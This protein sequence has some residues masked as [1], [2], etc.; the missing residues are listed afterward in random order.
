MNSL[1]GSELVVDLS[2]GVVTRPLC[3]TSTSGRDSA[4]FQAASDG[5]EFCHDLAAR[6]PIG[7]RH[8][9]AST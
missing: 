9:A 5:R 6:Y 8:I 4:S 2:G 7:P 3:Y 1:Y